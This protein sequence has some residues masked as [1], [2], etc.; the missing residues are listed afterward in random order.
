MLG[1]ILAVGLVIAVIGWSLWWWNELWYVVPL[2]VRCTKLGAK[3]PPGHMGLPFFGEKLAFF[4]Y[5]NILRRPNDFINSKRRKYGDNVGMYRSHLYKSPIIIACSQSIIKRVAQSSE[6][7][8]LEWPTREV[9]GLHSV[10]SLLGDHHKRIKSFI[11]NALNSPESVRRIVLLVQPHIAAAFQ[12]WAQKGKVKIFYEM[13]KVAF[14]YIGKYVASFE[15]GL[16][17]DTLEQLILG[18][19]KGHRA[20]PRKIPGT[21]YY[22]ALQCR[23]RI[24]EIFTAELEK[25]RRDGNNKNDIM[26]QLMQMKDGQGE[27]LSDK[28]VIDNLITMIY[29]STHAMAHSVAWSLYFLYKFPQ[30]LQKLRDEN[31]KMSMEKHG[32]YITR[33]DISKLKYTNKVVDETLRMSGIS[34]LFFR[35]ATDDINLDGYMIPKGWKVLLFVRYIHTDPENYEDPLFFNP[36]RWDEKS[37]PG[38]YPLFGYGQ[39]S[40]PANMLMRIYLAVFLHHISIGYKWELQ[41]PNARIMYLPTP[42]PA[43]GLE[44]SF[45]KL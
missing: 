18:L 23:K 3:L 24:V 13:K 4:W 20:H 9:L 6:E 14:V 7:F 45:T 37:A 11:S 33:D 44:V 8:I 34:G 17:L 39:R 27:Y 35:T 36:D 16:E 19:S 38:R 5:F 21:S 29:F 41:N 25:R 26:D 32:E 40:C 2:K 42:K 10:S 31:M 30:A 28:E 12:S 1:T 22:H 15:A 43:D